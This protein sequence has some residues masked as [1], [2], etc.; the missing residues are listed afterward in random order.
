MNGSQRPSRLAPF[1][2]AVDAA[3]SAQTN[4]PVRFDPGDIPQKMASFDHFSTV[5]PDAHST[6]PPHRARTNTRPAILYSGL[7]GRKRTE[8]SRPLEPSTRLNRNIETFGGDR[9]KPFL[10]RLA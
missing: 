6:Q 1:V 5:F 10:D 9:L 8:K 4:F 7:W 2:P 3:E